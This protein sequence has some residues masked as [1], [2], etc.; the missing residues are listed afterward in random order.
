V[1]SD[2]LPV[3]ASGA[4]MSPGDEIR[5]M[6]QTLRKTLLVLIYL[7]AFGGLAWLFW[8]GWDYYRSPL[9]ERPRLEQHWQLKPGGS[10]GIALGITGASMM[11]LMLGYSLRKRVPLLRPL[12]R[13]ASWLDGHIL[14]GIVGPG[15]IVLH[16]A[17]KVG[18]LVAVSFWSMVA[19]V[20]SG[21]LGRFLYVQLPRGA[22]GDELTLGEAVALD[23]ELTVELRDRFALSE[24]QLAELE[25]AA[26]GGLSGRQSLLALLLRLPFEPFL[27]RLRLA[28]FRHHCRQVPRPMFA[29][30]AALARQK[31]VL[32]RRLLLWSRVRE[33]FH[34]WH[35]AHKPFAILMYLFMLVHIGVAWATGYAGSFQ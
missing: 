19:V 7:A 14:L 32:R 10:R 28:R 35:V 30:F 13:L 31:A 33:L 23:D 24:A 26:A 12:G 15:M 2:S 22:A 16:T 8:D 6:R 27:M 17:F 18:G 20:S 5:K 4:T 25:T 34:Y 21:F 29:R 11:T 1:V 3:H 9:V